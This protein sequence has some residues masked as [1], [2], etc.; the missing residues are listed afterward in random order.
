MKIVINPKYSFLTEFIHQLPDNFASEGEIIYNE[1]NVLKHYQVQGV[2]L[3]VKSFKIPIVVNKVAYTFFRKSKACRSYQYG[4][5][6]LKRGG[7]TPEPIAYIEEYKRGILNRSYYISLYCA[8]T[9]T[10][11]HFM[12]GSNLD[13]DDVLSGFVRFTAGLHRAGILHIDYSPG[14]ILMETKPDGTYSFSVIDI[15]RLCFK[16]VSKEEAL[17]NFDRLALSSEISTRL[18]EL[19]ADSCSLDREETVM[20][21]NEYSDRFFRNLA[22]KLVRRSLRTD[23]KKDAALFGPLIK[24]RLLCW[25]R[26]VF[27]KRKKKGYLYQKEHDLYITYI[28]DADLRRV[29]A[30]RYQD[31]VSVY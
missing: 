4:L 3:I 19:Y 16:H 30:K 7:N 18:A 29:L 21:I 2:D 14:N 25:V 22:F 11:R 12:D 20:K 13:A 6:I 17:H 1:R 5:E 8:H 15:N 9:V 23:R 26:D 24:Y 27:C 28:K 10:M 31:I